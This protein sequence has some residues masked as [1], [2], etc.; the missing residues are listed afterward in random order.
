MKRP[1]IVI[2]DDRPRGLSALLDAVV[3]RYGADYQTVGYVSALSALDDLV[4]ARDLGED[5]ALVIADQWMPEMTGS[6]LL[7]RAHELHPEA[8]RALL[9]GWGD[10]RAS[11]V[12]LQ[13]CALG[14]LDNYIPKPWSPPELYLYPVIGEFLSEWSRSHGPRL[15]LVRVIAPDPSPRGT[16]LRD[17]LER[18]GIPHGF[19]PAESADGRK[20]IEDFRIDTHRLPA[21]LFLD[22]T[23][24]HD[25][26]NPE[27]ADMIGEPAATDPLYDLAIVGAGPCGL[28]AAVY[29]ASEGLQ[30]VVIER[31]AIGGQASSSSLI[32]NFLGF[33]RGITGADLAQRAYQQAWLFGAKYVLARAATG[34]RADA[35]D[36]VLTLED[37][38]EL[39]ARAVLIATG[40]AYRGLGIPRV[41]RFA[42]MGVLY[43]AGADIAQALAGRDVVV[44]GG[45]NSAGQAVVHL[46]KRARR[47]IHAVRGEALS[48]TMS[49]YLV[50]EI[51]RA[52]N[53][54]LRLHTEVI[55]A[56]GTRGLESVVLRNRQ[57]GAT[58]RVATPALFVM[59]GATP[60][61]EW[62]DGT[63]A[64]ERNGFVLTGSDVPRDAFGD[65]EPMLL[66]TSMPGV[67]AAGDAR[68]GSTKRLASAVGEA[69]VAIQIV[70]EYLQRSARLE[71]S[72]PRF[73]HEPTRLPEERPR[74]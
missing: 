37:G 33:P 60:H 6:E 29:A 64:R 65:R 41:D 25:P 56:D 44:C 50:Q 45:G 16:E 2:V 1:W 49:T 71:W 68:H 15:E 46:A 24:L 42:G 21:V 10:K 62:L 40:A 4:R 32:R 12:I 22:G 43:T 20:L 30:T 70:H 8:Q 26:S 51:L 5:V 54:D 67:F 72:G 36:H 73:E 38:R 13:G 57:T 17:L 18:S 35:D 53:V 58:E 31:E 39:R 66:E 48:H 63:V 27:L 74:A 61:T 52:T 47:V 11:D 19:H 14:Y 28:S 34:L 59:I 3:R 7:L 9:V 69:A 23:V 55:D